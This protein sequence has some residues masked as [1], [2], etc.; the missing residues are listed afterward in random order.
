MD[1]YS[2]M[3]YKDQIQCA[4]TFNYFHWFLPHINCPSK[5]RIGHC[6]DGGKWVCSP[7][8]LKQGSGHCLV[9]SFGSSDDFCFESDMARFG[10]E[11][12]IFDP[13]SKE[14]KDKRWTY[15]SWGIGGRDPLVTTYW[16]WRTQSQSSCHGCEMKTLKETMDTLNHRNIDVLKMDVDGAEWRSFDAIF[17][18]FE[19]TLP[20]EQL[21]IETTGLDMTAKNSY[22]TS[23]WFK[24]MFDKYDYALF[25]LE[26]NMG[27]CDYRPKHEG[28]S[29][30]FAFIKKSS[31]LIERADG[32]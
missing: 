28:T 14:I 4:H 12:H 20:F 2:E 22:R 1:W 19:T 21:Q 13:T 8:N 30:E 6:D 16:D 31:P 17:E 10:C 23:S 26:T 5:E 27:T 25:H 29:T 32:L 15:H 11:I 24:T 7:H 18:D 9:Y 3:V